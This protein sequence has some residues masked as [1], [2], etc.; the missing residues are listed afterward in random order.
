LAEQKSFMRILVITESL[1]V[2]E[3]SASK[4]NFAMVV[5]LVK[6]GFEVKVYHYSYKEVV[7]NSAASVLIK[8]NKFSIW[9]L[10]SRIQRTTQVLFKINFNN[11][12]EPYWGFSFAHTSDTLSIV[13]ALKKDIN[14][15]P[16][17]VLTLSKGGSFRPHRALFKLP[18]LH[19]KWMAYIHDPY[20]FHFYPRPYNW[21][22]KAY[23]HKE[24]FMKNVF[25]SAQYISYPSKLLMEWMESYFESGK[26]KGV[27]IPHQI[28][29]N[30][31]AENF[32]DYFNSSKFNLLHA[33]NLLKQ[34]NPEFLLKGFLLFL[35]KN[36]MA[37]LDSKLFLIGPNNQHQNLFLKY[38]NNVHII[39]KNHLDYLTVKL[40]ENNASVNIILE[41][42]SEI[43]PFLPGKFPN[44]VIA[45][46][47]ILALGPN[48]SEVKR[49][50]GEEYSFWSESDDFEKIASI[51][52][53]LYDFW[54]KDSLNLKLDRN[55]L[56][57]YCSYEYL[58]KVMIN[59][60]KVHIK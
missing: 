41:A 2:E 34:R 1:N 6:A 48:Y 42:V 36:P 26:G 45:N 59:L 39:V 17:L 32:P 13:K 52:E 24:L 37:E 31:V 38:E 4:V 29:D 15:N 23:H 22:E 49:L 44:L 40:L 53:T 7:I 3:N 51:I 19:S 46:N 60:K 30:T 33:G 9:Y 58:K 55:D 35:E 56:H 16:D 47:P 27:V 12:I 21:V 14:F 11:L 10:L 50:L 54:K 28:G 5:N 8:E 20:P 25:S 43:S 18:H 57:Y